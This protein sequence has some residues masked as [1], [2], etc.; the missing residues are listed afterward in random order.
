LVIAMIHVKHKTQT[1][2]FDCWYASIQM[3]KT[4]QNDG[5]K[6]KP[7]GTHTKRLHAGPFGHR[8]NAYSG[9]HPHKSVQNARVSKHFLEVLRENG[10]VRLTRIDLKPDQPMSWLKN[11][12]E[13]GPIMAGGTFGKFMGGLI[14]DLG[15]YVVVAGVD[16]DLEELYIHDPWESV[17]PTRMKIRDFYPKLWSDFESLFA[18]EPV[19][20]VNH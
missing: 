5:V 20:V 18:V 12:R 4:W 13:N 19:R 16:T 15:H 1:K 9:E 10:L 7:T 3:L 17:G 2:L 8:L 11:L 6:V 14:D